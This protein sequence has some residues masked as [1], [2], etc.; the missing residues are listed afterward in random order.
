[1][2]QRNDERAGEAVMAA[3]GGDE[4][5]TEDQEPIHSMFGLSYGNYLVLQRSL[6]EA[7]PVEWQR[8]FVAML[9]EMEAAFD[10]SRLPVASFH[11]QALDA[12][13]HEIEDPLSEYRRPDQG[14]I[15]SL[16]RKQGE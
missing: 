16:R 5:C 12:H 10:T 1:M 14:L 7:M 8:R 15:T 3:D 13:D 4:C 9:G 2:M 6:M 11:V